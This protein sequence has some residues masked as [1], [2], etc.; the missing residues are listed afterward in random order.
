MGHGDEQ[1]QGHRAL[2]LMIVEP[3]AVGG[4]AIRGCGERGMAR[5]VRMNFVGTMVIRIEFVQVHVHER[6]TERSQR[7]GHRQPD[8]GQRPNH[9]VIV[10]ETHRAVK[11]ERARA[12]SQFENVTQRLK[13]HG[14]SLR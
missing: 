2:G 14:R 5:D 10:R 11:P 12:V 1:L 9:T 4:C 13:L 3:C 8:R 6:S 7:D